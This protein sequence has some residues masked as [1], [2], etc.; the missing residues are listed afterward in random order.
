MNT[1]GNIAFEMNIY[2]EFPAE[3]CAG[4]PGAST[5]NGRTCWNE[6]TTGDHCEECA[7]EINEHQHD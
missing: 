6:A 3:L 4:I 2:Q 5:A 7:K 1:H